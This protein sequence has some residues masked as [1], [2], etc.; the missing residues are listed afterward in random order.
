MGEIDASPATVDAVI[1]AFVKRKVDD[2]RPSRTFDVLGDAAFSGSVN[3]AAADL[4][5]V[6]MA[7]VEAGGGGGLVF[8]ALAELP[9]DEGLPYLAQIAA[10]DGQERIGLNA[11]TAIEHM[12]TGSEAALERLTSLSRA[13]ALSEY[14]VEALSLTADRPFAR[15]TLIC[16]LVPELRGCE[17]MY[18]WF[19]G[20]APLGPLQVIDPP[21][22]ADE[23]DFR[24]CMREHWQE[25]ARLCGRDFMTDDCTTR[26][27]GRRGRSG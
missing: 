12:A 20:D 2:P 18:E 14:A 1:A 11:I 15:T 27:R 26:V 5:R 7:R 13:G 25:R 17:H 8:R 6:Y 16:V 9:D 23:A 24:G 10:Q 21:S 19:H 3:V 4:Y 22:C